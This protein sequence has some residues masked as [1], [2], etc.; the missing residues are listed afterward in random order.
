MLTADA[1][2][3]HSLFALTN[4]AG[5]FLLAESEGFEPPNHVLGDCLVSSEMLSARLSQLSKLVNYS[6]SDIKIV[7]QWQGSTAPIQF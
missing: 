7:K 2:L 4:S 1:L 3:I 5:L 6:T